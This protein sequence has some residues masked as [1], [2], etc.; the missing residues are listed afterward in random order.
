MRPLLHLF[1]AVFCLLS[2]SCYAQCGDELMKQALSS[3]GS[4]QY[5]KD[6][7]IK[8]PASISQSGMRFSVVLNSRTQYQVNVA[9]APT[10][11]DKVIIQIFD[12][13]KLLGTNF[14]NGRTFDV[15][16]FFCSKTGAYKLNVFCNSGTE[17][18]SRIVLSLVK[19]IP[20]VSMPQ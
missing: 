12:G 7:D 13:D 16:Q 4:Y 3:M 9:N 11:S 1:S 5:I 18:C 14:A 6:F 17:A 19:Q 10:N 8:L 15:F 2:P 20:Q